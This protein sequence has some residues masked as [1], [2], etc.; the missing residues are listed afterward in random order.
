MDITKKKTKPDANPA[1]LSGD[2]VTKFRHKL[3]LFRHLRSFRTSLVSCKLLQSLGPKCTAAEIELFWINIFGN[4]SVTCDMLQFIHAMDTCEA[5]PPDCSLKDKALI[6]KMISARSG[7]C[8]YQTLLDSPLAFIPFIPPYL[9]PKSMVYMGGSGEKNDA[10]RTNDVARAI[11]Y[12]KI[13]LIRLDILQSGFVTANE[14][15]AIQTRLYKLSVIKKAVFQFLENFCAE[16]NLPLEETTVDLAYQQ[17]GVAQSRKPIAY[18][19]EHL[20]ICTLPTEGPWRLEYVLRSAEMWDH[21]VVNRTYLQDP[22]FHVIYK[23]I[24]ALIHQKADSEE[25]ESDEDSRDHLRQ[26]AVASVDAIQAEEDINRE[27]VNVR[28]QERAAALALQLQGISKEDR[29]AVERALNEEKISQLERSKRDAEAKAEGLEK[30]LEDLEAKLANPAL[31]YSPEG[32]LLCDSKEMAH[33][34]FDFYE[35]HKTPGASLA[36]V[37]NPPGDTRSGPRGAGVSAGSP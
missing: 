28:E 11:V 7:E 21:E 5:W 37:Y 2:H 9:P 31:F 13:D 3:Q 12:R 34:N 24:G 26:L 36:E 14:I 20:S 30:R 10:F 22:D 17:K 1:A 33:R 23:K 25:S 18:G 8:S 27:L 19:E 29:A 6:Y 16:T 4:T 15:Q 32:G 35:H